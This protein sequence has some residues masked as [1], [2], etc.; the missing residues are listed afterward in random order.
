LTGLSVGEGKGISLSPNDA[1]EE[2]DLRF[3]RVLLW[4]DSL[5]IQRRFNVH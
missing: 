2:I 5:V 4:K 1:Y 3:T